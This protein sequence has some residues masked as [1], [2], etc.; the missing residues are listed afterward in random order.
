MTN[1]A[2]AHPF[3]IC[4]EAITGTTTTTFALAGPFNYFRFSAALAAGLPLWNPTG[5]TATAVGGTD[6]QRW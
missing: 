6:E 5:C 2:T 1:G 3:A 4:D